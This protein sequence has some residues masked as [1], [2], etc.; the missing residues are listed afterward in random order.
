MDR[1][2]IIRHIERVFRSC[3]AANGRKVAMSAF[4]FALVAQSEGGEGERL[5]DRGAEESVEDRI[6]RGIYRSYALIG[7]IVESNGD[8]AIIHISRHLTRSACTLITRREY[9]GNVVELAWYS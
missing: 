2:I 4:A 8:N 6:E 1:Q 3:S 9:V 7:R 5:T